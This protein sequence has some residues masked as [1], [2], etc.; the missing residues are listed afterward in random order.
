M[1]NY[2]GKVALLRFPNEAWFGSKCP[3][4]VPSY[5]F[6]VIVVHWHFWILL[7]FFGYIVKL[8]Y[9][10]RIQYIYIN[11]SLLY[12]INFPYYEIS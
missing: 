3:F 4:K 1:L 5:N 2:T 6:T 10:T 12:H 9:G 11:P 8:I 7:H